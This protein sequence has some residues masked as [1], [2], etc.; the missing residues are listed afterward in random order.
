MAQDEL[1]TSDSQDS[2]DIPRWH[3]AGELWLDYCDEYW[4]HLRRELEVMRLG[5]LPGHRGGSDVPYHEIENRYGR[6]LPAVARA[7]AGLR[8]SLAL[9]VGLLLPDTG[10]AA[11]EGEDE[12]ER[13]IAASTGWEE[14]V[15]IAL[16]DVDRIKG[17]ITYAKPGLGLT[18]ASGI[19]ALIL[20]LGGELERQVSSFEAIERPRLLRLS[21]TP[22][23]QAGYTRLPADRINKAVVEALAPG[24]MKELPAG[25]L[26]IFGSGVRFWRAYPFGT[27]RRPRGYDQLRGVI[28]LRDKPDESL[29]RLLRRGSALAVKIHLALWER[30]YAEAAV[31]AGRGKKPVP[32]PGD[33]VTTTLARL[34]DDIGLTRRKGT[35]KRESREAV[36]GLLK[37]LTSL[38]LICLYKPPRNV[39][40]QVIRGSV[41]RRGP[42]PEESGR[43]SDLFA[44]EGDA[45]PAGAPQ[46]FRYAP[47]RY[48]D[49]TDWRAHN[50]YVAL[51]HG[52]LLGVG[53]GN[54]HRWEVMIGAYLSVLARMNG[55]RRVTLRMQTLAEKMG[56]TSVYGRQDL[57]RMEVL[58]LKAIRELVSAGVIKEFVLNQE[59]RGDEGEGRTASPSGVSSLEQTITFKWPERVGERGRRLSD[60]KRKKRRARL[61]TKTSLTG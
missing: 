15:Q 37:L 54:E 31:E 61:G 30:A 25:Y 48:F 16:A 59:K 49:N 9:A 52:H 27:G 29:W 13:V 33:Y 53:C 60:R 24:A 43:Y 22:L 42:V 12:V 20:S 45:R 8:R 21:T 32:R 55:Y 35:H 26:D 5:P 14:A 58:M 36:A 46:A 3:E 23:T 10:V 7:A 1:N 41:W 6:R 57:S 34:C 44:R 50:R 18:A 17:L 51:V 56:M 11:P 38:E 28:G 4:G 40:P 39:P 19:P 47:G 2:F